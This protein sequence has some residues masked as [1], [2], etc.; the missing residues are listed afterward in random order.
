MMLCLKQKPHLT[1]S[2]VKTPRVPQ[3]LQTALRMFLTPGTKPEPLITKVSLGYAVQIT[4][5]FPV[6]ATISF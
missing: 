3:Y 4:Y 5:A 1:M 6:E 2:L